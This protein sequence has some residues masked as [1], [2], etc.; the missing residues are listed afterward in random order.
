MISVNSKIIYLMIKSF[1]SIFKR[2]IF[3]KKIVTNAAFIQE[4]FVKS[5]LLTYKDIFNQ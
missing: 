1:F 3:L 2:N 5:E 4:T